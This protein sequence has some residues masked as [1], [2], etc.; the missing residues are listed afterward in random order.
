MKKDQLY[1]YTFLG[2]TLITLLVSIFSMKYLF[3]VATNHFL[4]IHIESAKLQAR[5][6]SVLLQ[7]QIE[8]GLTKE[9]V[10]QNLQKTV[11]NSSTE[12]GFICM[13]DWSGVLLSHPNPEKVGHPV[14]HEDA[15]VHA[16]I[17]RELDPEDF[18]ELINNNPSND[19]AHSETDKSEVIYLYPVKDTDWIVAAYAN[20]DTLKSRMSNLKF[21]FLLVY[22]ASGILVV[23][24]SLPLVRLINSKYE[25]MLENQN[26]GLSKE[27][28]TLSKL[29]YDLVNYKQKMETEHPL[30]NTLLEKNQPIA[31]PAKK[32][33]MCYVKDEIVSVDTHSITFIHTQ[34][35]VTYISCLDHK[36]YYSNA[37]LDELY[38]DLDSDYFF[39]A[40]RQFIISIKAIDKIYKYGNNQ[41]KIV[42]KPDSP[43]D[44]I[45]SKNK[46]SEFKNWLSL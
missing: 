2:L 26:E 32:R 8:S 30:D 42:M 12:M 18:N 39:R 27:L 20:I 46:A 19:S 7:F 9:T 21:T 4:K 36:I 41:L 40:N 22:A 28:L 1:F 15:D 14:M 35:T 43:I 16:A 17:F 37:S 6:I 29:N 31:H 44:I 11:Q 5:E 33:I 3:T 24:L 13:I 10:I 23:L 34:N 38:N 45:V 25:K